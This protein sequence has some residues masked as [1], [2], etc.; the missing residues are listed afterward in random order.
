MKDVECAPNYVFVNNKKKLT[1]MTSI[2]I[3][4]SGRKQEN[5]NSGWLW[6]G[7]SGHGVGLTF[8][9]MHIMLFSFKTCVQNYF[10]CTFLGLL[11]T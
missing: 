9:L 7:K 2:C 4:I 5:I 6:G 11:K 10:K 8:F 3:D 1:R